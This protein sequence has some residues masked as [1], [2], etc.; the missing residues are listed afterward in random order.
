M[1]IVGS[2]KNQLFS[3]HFWV[4][5]VWEVD[6]VFCENLSLSLHIWESGGVGE[7]ACQ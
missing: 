7:G 2:S 3:D 6:S 5:V 1:K 4:T